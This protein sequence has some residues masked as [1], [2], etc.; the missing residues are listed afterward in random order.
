VDRPKIIDGRDIRAGDVLVGLGSAGLHSNGFSLAR[1]ALL[2][3]AGLTVASQLPELTRCLGEELLTPT[4]IY[5][6]QILALAGDLPIKGIAHITG[7]GLTG[8]LPR[9][10]PNGCHARIDLGSWTV[11]PIFRVIQKRGRVEDDEM[12]RVFNM[13]IGLVLVVSKD[14]ADRVI[15][16]AK[17]LGETGAVIGEIIAATDQ[18]PEVQYAGTI[19]GR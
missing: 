10:F 2:D 15:H 5:A 14:G 12:F 17:E 13:G 19:S 16:K 1:R 18:R 6:K 8:N 7:G 4:R 11:P 9:I 3:D